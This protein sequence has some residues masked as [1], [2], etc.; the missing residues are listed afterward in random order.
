MHVFGPL[1]TRSCNIT[2]HASCTASSQ[3]SFGYSIPNHMIIVVGSQ[4]QQTLFCGVYFIFYFGYNLNETPLPLSSIFCCL[5]CRICPLYRA[6]LRSCTLLNRFCRGR[7]SI[8]DISMFSQ[9]NCCKRGSVWHEI[10]A[11]L[12]H[13]PQKLE[14]ARIYSTGEIIQHLNL[15]CAILLMPFISNVAHDTVYLC[16]C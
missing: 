14:P 7:F 11:V 12:F 4:P 8:I 2:E 5:I 6:A 13:N 1:C 9:T 16:S 15:T 10:L 3:K